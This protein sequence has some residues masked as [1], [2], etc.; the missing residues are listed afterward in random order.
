MRF[1]PYANDICTN[2]QKTTFKVCQTLI[3]DQWDPL[4][5]NQVDQRDFADLLEPNLSHYVVN[6]LSSKL[7]RN[8]V[9]ARARHIASLS[10][11]DF[12]KS[13]ATAQR[14]KRRFVCAYQG[15]F[16]SAGEEAGSFY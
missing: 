7:K 9:S 16:S 3:C 5:M 12:I 10:S 8:F 13:P 11:G 4:K 1:L 14:D 15:P 6:N 2:K